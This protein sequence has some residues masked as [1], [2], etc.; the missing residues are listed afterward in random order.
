M[1]TLQWTGSN[2]QDI[3]AFSAGASV[4]FDDHNVI[5]VACGQRRYLALPGDWFIRDEGG[6]LRVC[7]SSCCASEV[8]RCLA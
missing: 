1:P 6:E 4:V 8:E 3:R 7:V 5:H 2:K